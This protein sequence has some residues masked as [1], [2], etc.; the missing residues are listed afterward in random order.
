MTIGMTIGKLTFLAVAAS[1]ALGHASAMAA[2]NG[3]SKTASKGASAEAVKSKLD[4]WQDR[5]LVVCH[6]QAEKKMKADEAKTYCSCMSEKHRAYVTKKVG[7]DA[8]DIDGH[9]AEVT[10]LYA[11]ETVVDSDNE[12]GAAD[13]DI[14]FS[15]A[16]LKGNKKP[17]GSR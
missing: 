7:R 2:G 13:L 5:F 1:V 14:D 4:K 10:A 12:P 8:I 15:V 17:S 6:T 16:C 11:S 3:L 9:L